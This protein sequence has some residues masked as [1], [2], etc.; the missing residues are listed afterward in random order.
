MIKKIL[1]PQD[2]SEYSKSALDYGIYLAREFGAELIGINVVDVVALEGPLL[3]DLSGSLGIEPLMNLSTR[4]REALEERGKVILE[5]FSASC[6]EAGVIHDKRQASGIVAT[7]ICNAAKLADLVIMGGR[8]LNARFDYGLLGS[9]TESVL[10]RSPQPVF[11]V[12]VVFKPIAAPLLAYDASP[13]A[14]RAMH[15]A[16]QFCKALKLPLTVITVSKQETDARLKEAEDYLKGYGLKVV[17]THVNDD[18]PVG[19]EGYYK[20]HAHDLL[21][22]GATH[23]AALVE[24]VLGSTTEHVMRRI[25]GPFFLER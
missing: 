11:V 6:A 13:N 15:S 16:A 23:H 18:P 19:I 8:G 20:E 24:M 10:R 14:A 2:G 3:H 1:I 17:Y 25:A 12:P 22:M 7:E 5:G 4:M 9:T 21:F